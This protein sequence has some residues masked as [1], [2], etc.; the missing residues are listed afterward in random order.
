MTIWLLYA[1][2]GLTAG[3]LAG[4]LGVGGGIVVVPVLTL[5]F[6]WQK[7]DPL[8]AHKIALGTSLATICLTSV[9]SLRAHA[10]RGAVDFKVLRDITPGILIGTFAGSYAAKIL[11]AGFLRGF[12]AFF[13]LYVGVQM[14]SDYKPKAH[15]ELPGLF[16]TSVVGLGIGLVSALVGIGGGTM[17]VPFL[18][19]C[20]VALHR[21][22][23][24]SAAV[25]FPI[26]LAGALGFAVNGLGVPGIP[27]PSVGF[28]YLPAFAG[29]AVVS[30]LVAPLG[31]RAAH[32]LPVARLK[33]VFGVFLLLMSGR[34][35]WQLLS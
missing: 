12:M 30:M 21:A 35:F 25:G 20:N 3:V 22:V 27:E 32:A 34:M 19:F 26:A 14:L 15:R 8:V 18:V 28:I 2:G 6:E 9:S 23:G 29:I 10:A 7:V 33:K 5:I 4:L 16:V 1:L 11:S 17:T 13:L 31:A 24:T